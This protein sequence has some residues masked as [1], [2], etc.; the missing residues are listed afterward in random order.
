MEMRVKVNTNDKRV[1][2]GKQ[3]KNPKETQPPPVSLSVCFDARKVDGDGSGTLVISFIRVSRRNG[4][5]Q[6]N[7][8]KNKK[9][10]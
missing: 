1:G 9:Q 3:N 5:S 2:N 10:R 8:I 4:S 7:R 6:E